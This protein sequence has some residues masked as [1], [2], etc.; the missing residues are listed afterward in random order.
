MSGTDRRGF[1]WKETAEALHL[2]RVAA[3]SSFWREVKRSRPR[4]GEAK[5]SAIDMR[6]ERDSDALKLR[7]PKAAR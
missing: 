3:R 4:R 6:D 2:T 1:D 5:P 7:K